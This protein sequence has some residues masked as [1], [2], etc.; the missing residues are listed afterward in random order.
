LSR[1]RFAW[2]RFWRFV[3]R[4]EWLALALV[5]IGAV[6]RGD[7]IAAALFGLPTG[8][9]LN[10]R[11][12]CDPPRNEIRIGISKI[13]ADEFRRSIHEAVKKQAGKGQTVGRP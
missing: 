10:E 7:A 2:R 13:D 1:L 4:W 12:Q 5:T 9:R 11:F 3:D 6:S 8:I